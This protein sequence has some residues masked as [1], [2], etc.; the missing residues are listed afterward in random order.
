[1]KQIAFVIFLSLVSSVSHA[2]LTEEELVSTTQAFIAAK[3]ARQQP[4]SN[5]ADVDQFL[6]FLDDNVIDEHVKFN[7]T[8]TNKAA[9][10]EGMLAK[11]ED[12]IIF[13]HMEIIDMM[14]G[15]NVVFVKFKEHAKGQ[16]SHLTHP[17]EYTAINI[18]SLEFNEKGK[19]AHIRRHHGM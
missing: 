15:K 5:V 17:I 12:K 13:S 18:M 6:S 3:N 14:V 11:L 4:D 10:R 9:L 19:I 16:P 8:I 7:V 1:V 2:E